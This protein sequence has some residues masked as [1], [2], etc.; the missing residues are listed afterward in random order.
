[1]AKNLNE[2]ILKRLNKPTAEE[3]GEQVL[4]KVATTMDAEMTN[5]LELETAAG[6]VVFDRDTSG[7]ISMFLNGENVPADKIKS[8]INETDTKIKTAFENHERLKSVSNKI[9]SSSVSDLVKSARISVKEGEKLS[10]TIL[11]ALI[12]QATMSQQISR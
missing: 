7:K 4:E 12:K 11:A 5:H 3:Y 10:M 1:M 8:T 2:T 6:K 9:V